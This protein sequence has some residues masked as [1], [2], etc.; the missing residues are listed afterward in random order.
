MVS[1]PPSPRIDSGE[2]HNVGPEKIHD[3]FLLTTYLFGNRTPTFGGRKRSDSSVAAVDL[4]G[5]PTPTYGIRKRPASP[6]VANGAMPFHRGAGSSQRG[7]R[8]FQRSGLQC[9]PAVTPICC[10]DERGL[11][12][13]VRKPKCGESPAMALNRFHYLHDF[14]SR[15]LTR[16][17][18]TG[19]TSPV[20]RRS[21]G[22]L[23]GRPHSADDLPVLAGR[24]YRLAGS[25]TNSTSL[26]TPRGQC[27]APGA[28]AGA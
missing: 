3:A 13:A 22:R 10:V 25:H 7:R 2:I 26:P 27:G 8:S 21:H 9:R 11:V 19:T 28:A 1:S 4:L 24:H 16:S 12:P 20:K 17:T 5:N 15:H 23:S 6:V 18:T 14:N